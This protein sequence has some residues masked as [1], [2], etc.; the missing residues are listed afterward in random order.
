MYD[1]LLQLR[2]SQVVKLFEAKNKWKKTREPTI[3]MKK[4]VAMVAKRGSTFS[5]SH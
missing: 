4:E 5:T 3:K 2:H 1:I